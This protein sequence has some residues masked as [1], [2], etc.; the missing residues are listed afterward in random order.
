MKIFTLN[1]YDQNGEVFI[2]EGAP[3]SSFKVTGKDN[4]E[5]TLYGLD[6]GYFRKEYDKK[7]EE[8]VRKYFLIHNRIGLT[9]SVT[10]LNPCYKGEVKRFKQGWATEELG[11]NDKCFIYLSNM[12]P[13]TRT[14]FRNAK[15][16]SLG[17]T[18]ISGCLKSDKIITLKNGKTVQDECQPSV[19]IADKD[20]EY[21]IAY[22][23]MNTKTNI[24]LDV[25]FDGTNLVVVSNSERPKFEKRQKPAILGIDFGKLEPS[26]NNSLANAFID[27]HDDGTKKGKKHKERFDKNDSEKWN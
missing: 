5:K 14:R 17:N 6:I 21:E 24:L 8:R 10:Y 7:P 2:A 11:N 27:C 16:Y 15:Q 22:F 13:R 23:N 26:F 12:D 9:D 1:P 25:K 3:L 19:L 20:R 4:E 18:L